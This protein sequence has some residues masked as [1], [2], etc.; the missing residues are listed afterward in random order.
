[1]NINLKNIGRKNL[2]I[3]V[4]LGVLLIIISAMDFKQGSSGY[5][6]GL[7]ENN[8]NNTDSEEKIEEI[9]ESINGVG[10]CKVMLTYDD[11]IPAGIVVVTKCAD[12]KEKV[13]EIT[14]IIKTLY[15]I[16]THRIKVVMMK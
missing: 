2:I 3:M 10:E 6:Y 14:D 1:M 5:K 7:S 8:K 11:N 12:N 13:L 15:C 4:L 16:P 9:L